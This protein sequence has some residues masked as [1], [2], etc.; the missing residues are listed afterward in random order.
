MVAAE[1]RC[2]PCVRGDYYGPNSSGQLEPKIVEAM[3]RRVCS[4]YTGECFDSMTETDVEHIVALSEAHDSGLCAADAET[5]S[6]FGH[7]LINLTLADP[8]TNRV[9]KSDRDAADLQCATV[10]M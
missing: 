8:H 7:D 9:E 4:P 6:R 2:S 3:G 1:S 10:R 5:R